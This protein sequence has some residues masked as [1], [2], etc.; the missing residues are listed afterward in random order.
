M[1]EEGLV[2]LSVIAEIAVMERQQAPSQKTWW[3]NFLTW[4]SA[5][6]AFLTVVLWIVT[7]YVTPWDHRVSLS[8]TFHIGVWAGFSGDILGRLVF[9]NDA[10]YGP[11]RGSII[12]LANSDYPSTGKSWFWGVGGLGERTDYD[13]KGTVEI[14]EL[15]CDF[16]G[17]YYRHFVWVKTGVVLWTLM[18]S[19][20]YPL[21]FFGALPATYCYRRLGSHRKRKN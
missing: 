17:I 9:F 7:F 14:K 19:L 6:L 21:L 2:G 12:T 20:W 11:Y 3:L 10:Q 13:G 5:F 8:R 1:R 18:I 15:G 16:P 4:A